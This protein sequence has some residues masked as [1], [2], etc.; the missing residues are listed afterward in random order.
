[1]TT[2]L[3]DFRNFSRPLSGLS[4]RKSR[5]RSLIRDVVVL[6]EGRAEARGV[7]LALRDGDDVQLVCDPQ[8]IKQAV[9]NLVQNALDSTPSGGSVDVSVRVIALDHAEVSVRDTGPGLSPKV[10]DRLFTPGVTTKEHG[11]GIGLVVARSIADQHGGTLRLNNRETGGCEAVLSLPI[12]SEL[13]TQGA[14]LT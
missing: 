5:L 10:V 14:S 11:T 8:K 12:R 7:N 4:L 1:M 9:L 2:V 6:N 3:D 13:P